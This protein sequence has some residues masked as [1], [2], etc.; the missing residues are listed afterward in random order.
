MAAT[1]QLRIGRAIVAFGAGAGAMAYFRTPTWREREHAIVVAGDHRAT[2]RIRERATPPPIGCALWPASHVLLHWAL[3][4]WADDVRGARVLELGAGCGLTAI[5]LALAAPP[6]CVASVLATDACE[7]A[8]ANCERNVASN[9]AAA[10][11][12]R[13]A[14]WD[15][16]EAPPCDVREVTHLLAA[17][18]VY[19]GASGQQL[20]ERLAELLTINP[21]LEIALLLVDR[22]SGGAV[23][24]MNQLVGVPNVATVASRLD[25]AVEA[26]ERAAAAAGLS[27]TRE[28]MGAGVARGL[29]DS[30]PFGERMRWLCLG[31]WDAMRLYRVRPARSPE[32]PAVHV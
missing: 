6:G 16:R 12:V 10:A 5:G 25:P 2:V 21:R 8:L 20:V 1:A 22:F 27:A 23:A 31:T 18:V 28:P 24:G 13:A 15:V 3:D 9:G 26:F 32:P 29:T 14:R 17:D 7:A 4:A 30:L 19:H 11:G